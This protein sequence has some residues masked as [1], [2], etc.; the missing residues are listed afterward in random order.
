M[1]MRYANISGPTD[2]AVPPMPTIG[3]GIG[4]LRVS[5]RGREHDEER[6]DTN[7]RSIAQGEKERLAA[8]EDKKLLDASSF[9]PDSCVFQSCIFRIEY[10]TEPPVD[11]KSKLA[12]STEAEIKSLQSSLRGAKEDT[13]TELQRNVFKKCVLQ[14]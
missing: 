7:E 9:D 8:E 2:L 4:A 3:T 1:S 14:P 11:L 5:P 10:A 6:V 12:N 13:D